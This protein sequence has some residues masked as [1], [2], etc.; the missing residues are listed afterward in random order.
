MRIS[1]EECPSLKLVSSSELIRSSYC[2]HPADGQT[3]IITEIYQRRRQNNIQCNP[4]TVRRLSKAIYIRTR[5]TEGELIKI[6]T[7]NK[8]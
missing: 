5:K 3:L 2:H 1:Q 8:S 4:C 6:T 7:N